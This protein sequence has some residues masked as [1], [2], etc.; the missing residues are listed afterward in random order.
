[1]LQNVLVQLWRYIFNGTHSPS[2]FRLEIPKRVAIRSVYVAIPHEQLLLL[3]PFRGSYKR[4][5]AFYKG[6]RPGYSWIAITV[7]S[8]AK[9]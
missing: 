3:R 7:V 5:C 1:M 4:S 8:E 6:G 2:G 9:Y